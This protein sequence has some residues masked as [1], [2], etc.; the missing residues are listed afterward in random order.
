MA[1]RS[2]ILGFEPRLKGNF[3]AIFDVIK[4][5]QFCCFFTLNIY[6][7]HYWNIN[8]SDFAFEIWFVNLQQQKGI[9]FGPQFSKQIS[10]VTQ[11]SLVT[12]SGQLLFPDL[13]LFDPQPCLHIALYIFIYYLH[14]GSWSHGS[15]T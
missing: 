11:L 13:K 4:A 6:S 3:V 8:D 2:I 15:Y 10:L 7:P 5:L 9:K 14:Y 1:Q 12:I